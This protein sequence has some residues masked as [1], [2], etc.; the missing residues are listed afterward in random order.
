MKSLNLLA[1]AISSVAFLPILLLPNSTPSAFALGCVNVDV[2]NQVKITG[3][4]A[5]PGTQQNN[6]NQVIDPNCLGNANVHN[7][8]QTHVGSEGADQTRN[9]SQYS[10]GLGKNNLVPASV[11][12]A[13]NVNVQTGTATTIYAPGLDPKYLPKK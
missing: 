12:D 7:T 1:L 9:S 2:S 6:V 10:G 4:K 8:T 11:M 5:H 3:S 13:G